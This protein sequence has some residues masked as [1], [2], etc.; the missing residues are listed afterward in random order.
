MAALALYGEKIK[1]SFFRKPGRAGFPLLMEDASYV[2]LDTELTGFNLKKDSVVSIGAV[3]M[4]GTRIELGQTFYRVVKPETVLTS[5]SVVVHEITPSE[6]K[7]KPNIGATLIE[8]VDFLKGC[9][10]VGHFVS[11]DVGFLSRDAKKYGKMRIDNP[12]VDTCSIFEFLRGEERGFSRHFDDS[13]VNK[14][15]FSIAKRYKIEVGGAHNALIDAFITAQVFQRFLRHL[16]RFGVR[17]FR[18]L[19]Q[20]GKP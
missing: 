13:I 5:R 18:D 10:I 20:V 19:L 6:V 12:V 3:K 14:D 16:P 1:F 17:T 11:L 7:Q 15:L 4:T 2:V 8:L 9:V